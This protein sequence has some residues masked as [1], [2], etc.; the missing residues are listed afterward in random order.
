MPSLTICEDSAF[1]RTI[2]VFHLAANQATGDDLNSSIIGCSERSFRYDRHDETIWISIIN[3]HRASD[4]LVMIVIVQQYV[5]YGL[6]DKR[7]C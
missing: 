7:C 4:L 6:D 1:K 2:Q 5:I 3:I